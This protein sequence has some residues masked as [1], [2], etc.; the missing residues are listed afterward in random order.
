MAC[1][2]ATAARCFVTLESPDYPLS[3]AMATRSSQLPIMAPRVPGHLQGEA[4]EGGKVAGVAGPFRLG[5]RFEQ[6]ATGGDNRLQRGVD[7]LPPG[8]I[9]SQGH[10][11]E[12]R[13]L[14]ADV[15]VR[16][17]QLPPA[18]RQHYATG[19]E[20]GVILRACRRE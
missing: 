17:K 5:R 4:V 19:V 18:Q 20:E 16:G 15:R 14:G 3:I 12:A 11:G 8:D 2:A 13:S 9:V 6:L 7:Q 10:P 1:R